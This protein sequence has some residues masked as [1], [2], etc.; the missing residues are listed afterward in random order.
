MSVSAIYVVCNFEPLRMGLTQ[1]ISEAD[2]LQL[3][4]SSPSLAEARRDGV[5]KDSATYVI[6]ASQISEMMAVDERGIS[7][8]FRRAIFVGPIPLSHDAAMVLAHQLHHRAAVGF[9]HEIG[10]STRLIEAISLVASGAFVCEMTM[11]MGLRAEAVQADAQEK[12]RAA[13]LSPREIEVLVLVARGLANKEIA[14]E[15]YLAEG[16]VKAHVSHVLAKLGVQNR[17]DLVRFGMLLE[18][19]ADRQTA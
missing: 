3:V 18:S 8:P 10:S 13:S 15:L 2:G 19:G 9:I 16:T 1:V 4:G 11:A 12:L 17:V 14:R 6:D 7:H 5:A